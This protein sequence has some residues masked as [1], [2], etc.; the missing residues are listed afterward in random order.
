[1]KELNK[2]IQ[3]FLDSL[4]GPKDPPKGSSKLK[5][6]GKIKPKRKR[7]GQPGNQNARKHGSYSKR[8]TPQQL[9]K[10]QDPREMTDLSREIGLLC[11]KLNVL[12]KDPTTSLDS[13]LKCLMALAELIRIQEMY[14]YNN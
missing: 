8:L 13:I 14:L 3:D 9:E 2:E 4:T 5:C 12:R 1:M 6:D 11:V 7:G 10:F